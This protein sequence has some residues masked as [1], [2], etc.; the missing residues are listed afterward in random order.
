[1]RIAICFS[2]H[3]RNFFSKGLDSFDKNLLYLRK[4]GHEVDLFFSVWDTYEPSTTHWYKESIISDLIDEN[5]IKQI[6]PISYVIEKYENV[7][8]N[9]ILKNI[10]STVKVEPYPIISEDGILHSTPMYYKILS[11]NNLKKEYEIKNNFKYDVVIRYRS[12]IYMDRPLTLHEIQP[13]ILYVP[14]VSQRFE[15]NWW[16]NSQQ[17]GSNMTDD[18]LAYGDSEIMDTYSDVYNNLTLLFEKYGNTGPERI[19]DN[20][21]I[22]ELKLNVQRG[23]D[24]QIIR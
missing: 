10:H 9:F 4:Q 20:W 23:I 2:G 8:H 14:Y 12:H 19:L 5:L 22:N 3:I 13:N 17:N 21:L 16:E 15:Y 6:N 7:K 1:M 18:R 11:A 24:V